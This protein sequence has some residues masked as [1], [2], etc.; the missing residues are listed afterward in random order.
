VIVVDSGGIDE[1]YIPR[2]DPLILLPLPRKQFKADDPRNRKE[3][4]GSL[5]DPLRM[6][7]LRMSGSK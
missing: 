5:S 4:Q 3:P 6:Q 1:R 2:D 7:Y